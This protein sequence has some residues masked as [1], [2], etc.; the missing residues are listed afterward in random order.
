[1]DNLS[2]EGEP[3]LEVGALG[4]S[5]EVAHCGA[6]VLLKLLLRNVAEVACHAVVAT[7]VEENA[8]EVVFCKVANDGEQIVLHIVVGRIEELGGVGIVVAVHSVHELAVEPQCGSPRLLVGL[9]EEHS[10]LT[11]SIEVAAA[12]CHGVHGSVHTQ[13][14]LMAYVD[15]C[16]KV[17]PIGCTFI[18]LI[19]RGRPP[20]EFLHLLS[21]RRL[22]E[23]I[24]L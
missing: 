8:V 2:T 13:S 9:A 7:A 5:R 3:L 14:Q 12:A 15:K 23:H 21:Y 17:V 18:E 22:E 20:V 1:M 10:L 6:E 4:A 11:E 16:L 24:A 19:A